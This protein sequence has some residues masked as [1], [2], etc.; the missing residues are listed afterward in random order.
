MHRHGEIFTHVE[1]DVHAGEFETSLMQHLYPEYVGEIR[2]A[3]SE[4]KFVPQAFMDYFDV[5]EVT[6]DGYWGFP[7]AATPAK[8]EQA[9]ALLVECGLA[10]IEEVERVTEWV[11]SKTEAAVDEQ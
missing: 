1:H 7:E 9:L 6:D 8:G 10:Y 4:Q 11:R 3:G 5:T 2:A